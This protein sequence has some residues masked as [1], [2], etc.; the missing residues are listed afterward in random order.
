MTDVCNIFKSIDNENGSFLLFSQYTNDLAKSAIDPGFKVRPSRFFCLKLGVNSIANCASIVGNQSTG[1]TIPKYLQN[2]FENELSYMRVNKKDSYTSFMSSTDFIVHLIQILLG[3]NWDNTDYS[4]SVLSNYMVYDGIIDSNSWNDGFADIILNIPSGSSKKIYQFKSDDYNKKTLSEFKSLIGVVNYDD[5]NNGYIMGWKASDQIPI[6][7][8]VP[9]T[10]I[11][12]DGN[13]LNQTVSIRDSI[14]DIIF[15]SRNDTDAD[16]FSFNTILICYNV[17]DE[18][19]NII[20]KDIPMG[21]YFTGPYD[22][23]IYNFKNYVT[24]YKTNEDALGVGSSWSLRISTKFAPT[25]QGSLKV[26][27]VATESGALTSS[28]SALMSANAEM[29]KTINNMSKKMWID[30]Q[31]Y[32]DLLAIFKDGRT[33]IPYIKNI[34]G[35]NYWFVNGRNTNVQV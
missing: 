3:S 16:L 19:N 27:N 32:R 1:E 21:I 34:N 28:I 17:L 6:S 24:I 33:N 31:S 12:Y 2:Y 4:E 22:S 29:I 10:I 5:I 7:G 35:V 25:P 9:N 20:Y 15:N 30:T 18:H 8:N 14:F 26:E 11:C 23:S 13:K